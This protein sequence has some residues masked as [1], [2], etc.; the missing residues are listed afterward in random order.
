MRKIIFGLMLLFVTLAPTQAFAQ[1]NGISL[2]VE[3]GFDRYYVE[4]SWIP[5]QVTVAND[6]A[7]VE[8]YLEIAT[9]SGSSAR[10]Y[11]QPI[12]LPNQSRKQVTMYVFPLGSVGQISVR[13]RDND[14]RSL[15]L[16][17]AESV[18]HTIA[19]ELLYAVVSDEAVN[20]DLLETITGAR[21]EA[22]VAYLSP[23]DLPDVAATWGAID[24]LMFTHVD[25]S[26]LTP[27]QR[28]NVRA[29]VET[30]GVL[31]VMGGIEARQTAAV[32]ADLLPITVGDNASVQGL[33]QLGAEIGRNLTETYLITQT[34]L[35]NGEVVVRDGTNSL[36]TKRNLGRGTVFYV[37]LDSELDPLQDVAVANAIWEPVANAVAVPFQWDNGIEQGYSAE[38]AATIFPN[39]ALPSSVSLFGFLLVY[40][41]I[42][43]PIN[44]FLLK[45]WQ[46]REWAWVTIPIIVLF[47]LGFAYTFGF[48]FRGENVLVN[49]ISLAVVSSEAETMRVDSVVGLYSPRRATYDL[50]FSAD[51]LIYLPEV[52]GVGDGARGNTYTE[53]GADHRLNDLR[54]DL[55]DVDTV[56]VESMQAK[57]DITGHVILDSTSASPRL[58]VNLFNDSTL[59]L[60]NVS[61]YLGTSVIALGDLDAGDSYQDL[62]SVPSVSADVIT[63]LQTPLS[64]TVELPNV[65]SDEWELHTQLATGSITYSYNDPEWQMRRDFFESVFPYRYYGPSGTPEP[66]H[67]PIDA[68]TVVA[69]SNQSLAEMEVVGESAET[70]AT[71]LYF[72]EIPIQRQ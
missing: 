26:R 41:I 29:W 24:V 27:V 51:S 63:A 39:L 11:H 25:S 52:F 37:A 71:T 35:Q 45:R 53:W 50:Q 17:A 34:Q 44:Y 2:E 28:A 49:E 57:P 14:G 19:N 6:G 1:D 62:L 64:T 68:L 5:V 66:F 7:D 70:T 58:N 61:I 48:Q 8:G 13:L 65:I 60:V 55:A 21:S 9:G 16:A 15:K 42:L 32:F 33:P 23:A 12:V 47:F 54:I 20:L 31:V 38:R 22:N 36:V 59:D 67:L 18:R 4:D 30:G 43:G 69:W 56:R 46:R 10:R 40:I 72:I 3:A